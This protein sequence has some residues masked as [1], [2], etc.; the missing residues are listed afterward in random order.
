[1]PYRISVS[2]LQVEC[3]TT[4]E[5]LALA[6]DAQK[7][8]LSVQAAKP[9]PNTHS[10]SPS[11][12]QGERS[13]EPP[14]GGFARRLLTIVNHAGSHGVLNDQLVSALN[15]AGPRGLGPYMTAVKKQLAHIGMGTADVVEVRRTAA[16]RRWFPAARIQEALSKLH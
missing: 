7:A 15:L 3:D 11:V 16:G 10:P 2:G 5:V 13:P 14:S 4:E 6:A 8:G 12:A 1:M 9:E